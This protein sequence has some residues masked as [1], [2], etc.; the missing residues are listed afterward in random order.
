MIVPKI[1]YDP[2]SGPVT[3]TPTYPNVKKP[4]GADPLVAT[5]HDSIT[6]SGKKQSVT[7][8]VDTLIPVQFDIVPS[9]DMAAWAAFMGWALAGGV[10]TWYPDSTVSGTHTDYTLEDMAWQP[11]FVAKDTN[12]FKFTM[13]KVV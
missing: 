11:T 12:S 4:Q 2:G 8:R 3:L 9:S 5:R 10:F 13:R 7:E 1:V 6:S